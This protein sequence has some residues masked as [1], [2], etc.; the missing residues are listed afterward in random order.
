MKQ[1]GPIEGDMP[2][3][4]TI[5]QE[6]SIGEGD[7]T[8]ARADLSRD[9]DAIEDDVVEV[10]LVVPPSAAT[11][12][13]LNEEF[14]GTG[15][16]KKLRAPFSLQALKQAI[17]LIS[18]SSRLSPTSSQGPPSSSLVV[19]VVVAT[20]I[21]FDPPV[22]PSPPAQGPPSSTTLAM[23]APLAAPPSSTVVSLLSASVETT[24]VL[25]DLSPP[26]PALP[27]LALTV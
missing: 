12:G 8:K 5:I 17:G 21:I 16:C 20:T 25:V 3:P 6:P 27:S 18:S 10:T 11:T 1:V 24:S 15:Q 14:G 4:P 2:P 9:V 7:P 23:S 13:K 19:Q 26:S 22:P